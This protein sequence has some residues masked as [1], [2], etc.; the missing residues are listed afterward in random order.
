MRSRLLSL[1]LASGAL[2]PA[3][4]EGQ[5]KEPIDWL[6]LCSTMVEALAGPAHPVCT[7][8]YQDIKATLDAASH[9]L[10]D[11]GFAAPA[12]SANL[13]M[14][15]QMVGASAEEQGVQMGS[16]RDPRC[17]KRYCAWLVYE[18]GAHGQYSLSDSSLA[19][20]PFFVDGGRVRV[21][22]PPGFAFTEVHELFHAI[23][24]GYPRV[25]AAEETD[26]VEW[27][28]EGSADHVALASGRVVAL[29]PGLG[30][31][32]RTYDQ[33]LHVPPSEDANDPD[34]SQ[35]AYGTWEFWDFLGEHL[36]STD[37]VQYLDSLLSI[38]R[39]G[40]ENGLRAVEAVVRGHTGLGLHDA[41]P[42]FV[43]T[44]LVRPCY[45][46]HLGTWQSGN[47]AEKRSSEYRVTLS[48][49][50]TVTRAD[51]TVPA[52]AANG[53]VVALAVPPGKTGGLIIRVPPDRDEKYLHLI[54]GD[55]RFD[56]PVT[57]GRRNEHVVLLPS[58]RHELLVRLANVP[59]DVSTV[60]LD[61]GLHFGDPAPIEFILTEET[62]GYAVTGDVALPR[63]VVEGFAVA[64][65]QQNE[66]A[67]CRL[68]V[69]LHGEAEYPIFGLRALLPGGL[70]PGSY[71]VGDVGP[72]LNQEWRTEAGA[73]GTFFAY[74][75]LGPEHGVVNGR[76]RSRWF[77]SASGQVNVDHFD[78]SN[79]SL[80]F[81]VTLRETGVHQDPGPRTVR[82]EGTAARV[83]GRSLTSPG[84][85]QVGTREGLPAFY[86]CDTD[87]PPP[88]SLPPPRPTPTPSPT[89]TP[90]PTPLPTPEPEPAP[91][92]TPTREPEP[93]PEPTPTPR[94]TPP[95]PAPARQEEKSA[96]AP[97][98]PEAEPADPAPAADAG[99]HLTGALI[100]RFPEEG[101]GT[102][103]SDAQ[104]VTG[105][106]SPGAIAVTAESFSWRFTPPPQELGRC[107]F[108][109]AI[110]SVLRSLGNRVR[111]S[112]LRLRMRGAGG[113]RSIE[114]SIFGD[115]LVLRAE[116]AERVRV[117]RTPAG[118]ARVEVS[119]ATL[120][121]ITGGRTYTCDRLLDFSFTLAEAGG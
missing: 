16:Q 76:L 121:V 38:L 85:F 116:G 105:S 2:C 9:W 23:Q 22:Y 30:V 83:V 119:D 14:A 48:F 5:W 35:W 113:E 40:Q 24:E 87:A 120:D 49:P 51:H 34:F 58:G 98:E 73:P 62:G 99:V 114:L 70:A 80:S 111:E 4:V 94:P 118:A 92:P 28:T 54:V 64:G 46:S 17:E 112:G 69:G 102:L 79:L 12:I 108:P 52:M 65:L 27:I 106:G 7:D 39:P 78:G 56:G 32:S 10:R 13:D 71:R 63:T 89:P 66:P 44:R 6:V 31:K 67:A 81:G 20:D 36:G 90:R 74:L 41:Y 104:A 60:D 95:S 100:L 75:E 47:C 86:L 53:Y 25:S 45:F 101:G 93:A 84:G 19:L 107:G 115:Q 91:E 110:E 97:A 11:L 18:L 50:D 43:R 1:L 103:R 29:S 109:P 21:G 57:L 55:Q 26:W 82:V 3:P 8:H 61:A 33:P 88:D 72:G 37:R 96:P 42:E 59:E 68:A 117:G 77:A 15:A